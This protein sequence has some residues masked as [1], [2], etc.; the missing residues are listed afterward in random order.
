M[1]RVKDLGNRLDV[2]YLIFLIGVVISVAF[3]KWKQAQSINKPP[4]DVQKG[5]ENI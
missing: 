3:Y 4:T 1:E 2:L 5:K